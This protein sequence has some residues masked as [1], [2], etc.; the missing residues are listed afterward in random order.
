[1]G[2]MGK[3]LLFELRPIASGNDGHFNDAEKVVQQRRHFSIKRRF[4]FGE[5]AV[6]V[7][8]DQLFHSGISISSTFTAPRGRKVHSPRTAGSRSTQPPPPSSGPPPCSPCP[9]P[10]IETSTRGTPAAPTVNGNCPRTR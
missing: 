5:C 7:I 2:K 4:A 9:L 6:Q 1:M 8:N 3:H 10:S